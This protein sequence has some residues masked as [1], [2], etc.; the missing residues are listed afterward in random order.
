MMSQPIKQCYWVV[1]GKFLAGNT[2]ETGEQEQYI[3]RWEE[4]V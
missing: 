2:W 1:P 3:L 4:P